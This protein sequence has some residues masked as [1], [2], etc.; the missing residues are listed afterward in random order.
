MAM[1]STFRRLTRAVAAAILLGTALA[2]A[3][4]LYSQSLDIPSEKWGLSFGNSKEFT[5]LRFNFRDRGVRRVAGVNFTLWMPHKK[6]NDAVVTGLSLGVVP[7]GGRVR[8]VH[9]GLLGAGADKSLTGL[10]LAGLG[11]GAGEDVEGV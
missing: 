10:T 1:T 6:D 2:A 5:G 8:G 11:A 7:G 4:V 9:L 3:P